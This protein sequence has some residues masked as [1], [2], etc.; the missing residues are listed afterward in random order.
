MKKCHIFSTLAFSCLVI[1]G[2]GSTLRVKGP[3]LF[4]TTGT[5]GN[6]LVYSYLIPNG[7]YEQVSTNDIGF[8]LTMATSGTT[9]FVTDDNIALYSIPLSGG[10]YTQLNTQTITHAGSV[11]VYGS[12]AYVSSNASVVTL[13]IT[14]GAITRT[15]TLAGANFLG[16]ALSVAENRIYV[17]NSVDG[18]VYSISISGGSFVKVSNAPLPA[19]VIG[20]LAIDGDTLYVANNSS[21]SQI[22]SLPLSGGDFSLISPETVP[23]VGS[24]AILDDTIYITSGGSARS[25]FTIPT[26]GGSYSFFAQT[27]LAGSFIADGITI[28]N[29][30]T[31][32]AIPTLTAEIIQTS[33]G[34][35]VADHMAMSR[36]RKSA[37]RNKQELL[38]SLEN[39]LEDVSSLEASLSDCPAGNS[40]YLKKAESSSKMPECPKKRGFY[41]WVQFFGEYLHE[42]AGHATPAFHAGAGERS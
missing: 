29:P 28:F 37:L 7:P 3:T 13:P 19:G 18:N 12:N 11:A 27:P 5:S 17:S 22:Y 42:K 10:G 36:V 8:A 1:S 15:E 33:I 40:K 16:L 30:P 24:M 25:I 23:G 41:P 34:L 4:V 31:W 6:G 21:P 38:A 39:D 9:G 14:G 2:Y 35:V 32:N 26:K 20:K